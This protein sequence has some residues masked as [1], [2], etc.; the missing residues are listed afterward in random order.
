MFQRFFLLL[1]TA[2]SIV[3]V[4]S[5]QTPTFSEHIAPIIFN[6]CVTCHRTGEIAPF[7]LTNYSEVRANAQ[8]IKY[9][10]S[11]GIMPPWKPVRDYGNFVD[12][13]RL[14]PEEKSNY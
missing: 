1:I 12:E 3:S 2:V 5:A 14:T 7:S 6:H 13:R 4:A 8:T 11:T 9:A 10:V